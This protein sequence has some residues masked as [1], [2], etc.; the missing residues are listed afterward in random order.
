MPDFMS[1][2]NGFIKN[3]PKALEAKRKR[4]I[5]RIG[6]RA[7]DTTP[8][9]D[10]SKWEDSHWRDYA[11]AHGYE[12]GHMKA[13]WQTAVN[14]EITSELTDGNQP[15]PGPI[16]PSGTQAKAQLAANLGEG[17]C[18]VYITNNVPYALVIE[19]GSSKQAPT[20]IV[21]NIQADMINL[22]I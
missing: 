19:H 21:R 22:V 8:V 16:D 12:G 4:V 15:Y 14:H 9:G 3:A 17:D 10:P 7:I 5:T 18:T 20:G 11:I 13:N 6:E 2:I 1:V